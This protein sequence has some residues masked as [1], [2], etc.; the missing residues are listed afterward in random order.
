MKR[1]LITTTINVPLNLEAYAIDMARHGYGKCRDELGQPVNRIVIAG[2]IKSPHD[3]IR[4]FVD[5]KISPYIHCDYLGVEE[6]EAF[7]VRWKEY[8]DFLPWNCIQRRNVAIL[9]AYF[10][11]A[12]IIY[13]VDDDNFWEGK[14]YIGQHEKNANRLVSKNNGWWNV[15]S[16]YGLYHRGYSFKYRNHPSL[17]F[18]W[19]PPENKRQVV[20]AGMWTGDP[21]VDAVTRL[22]LSPEIN[23]YGIEKYGLSSGTKSPFN[24]QNTAL[25][26]EVIPA[27]CMINGVGRY[28][29]IIPGYFVKRI[30]DHLGDYISFGC[31]VVHQERNNHDLFKDLSGEI[32]GMQLVDRIVDWLYETPLTGKNYKECLMELLP[33]FRKHSED[34]NLTSEQMD[35]VKS[36]C[37]NYELWA[38]IF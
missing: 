15:L 20:S 10:N 18:H 23:Y 24:S 13:T 12:D 9:S 8:R 4:K 29:D 6:Q 3:E 36:I 25:H 34:G 21:D 22:A 11:G 2:D 30:A 27:Y 1:A 31:P 35:F 28:D 7:L 37:R 26:R 33:V 5:E 14:D 16:S 38:E 17:D 19:E 32:L